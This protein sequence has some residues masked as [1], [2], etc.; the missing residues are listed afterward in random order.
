MKIAIGS[1]HALHS[2]TD[3]EG[4]HH[5]TRIRKLDKRSTSA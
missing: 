3:F 2:V 5:I 1:D 4:G